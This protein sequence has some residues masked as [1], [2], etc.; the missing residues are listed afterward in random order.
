M[1]NPTRISNL[2]VVMTLALT[3]GCAGEGNGLQDLTP[4][5]DS[6]INQVQDEQLTSVKQ[7]ITSVGYSTYLGFSSEDSGR[8]IAVDGVG[9]AYVCGY[10]S[11]GNTNN[12]FVAKMSPSGSNLYFITYPGT[13]IGCKDIAVDASGNAYV[14]TGPALTKINPTGTAIVYRATLGW[15]EITGVQVDAS[16]NAY[17]AGVV[18]N[19]VAGFDVAVGKVAPTGTSFVYAVAFGGTGNDFTNDLAIDRFGNAYITGFTNSDNFPVVNAFQPTRKGVEDAF[20]VR[21]NAT[22]TALTYSTYLGGSGAEGGTGI[23]VDSSGNA[24]VTGTTQPYAYDDFNDFPVTAGAV[25]TMSGGGYE[26]FAVKFSPAGSILYSTYIGGN[27]AD[28]GG[29]IAV[30]ST[31]AVYIMGNTSSV[32]FPTSSWAFQPFFRGGTWDAFVVQ[33]S[34]MFNAYTYSTYLGGNNMD[35]GMGIALDT[36]NNVYVTG[37]TVST[38]FPTTVYAR[39]GGTDAF[40]TRLNGP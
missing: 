36:S 39:G 14:V 40:V 27:S 15:R 37:E 4:S 10:T 33:L 31:G 38:N 7:E 21:L 26:A 22:G 5:A 32:N 23:A 20:V 30:S 11:Y 1:F 19:G 2:L 16:G 18:D 13:G 9:N 12:T 34:P 17:V 6:K 25:Q 8:G 35:V 3:A 28:Y 24:Y 29:D